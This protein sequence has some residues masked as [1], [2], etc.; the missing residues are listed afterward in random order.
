MEV[1]HSLNFTDP[2]S[3]QPYFNTALFTRENLGYLGT[4]NRAFFHGPGINNWDMSLQKDTRLTESKTLQL[5][6]EFFNA[7]NHAQFG[8]PSGN[9]SSGAFGLVTGAA[10]PR[11][12][13][14]A[15]KLIF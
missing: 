11:I 8:N 10:S 7:F 9:I 12:G 1:D 15:L 3:G 13:Q 14:V 5:R 6:A 2:R 4:A